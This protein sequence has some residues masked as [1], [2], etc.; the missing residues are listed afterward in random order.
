MQEN[1]DVNDSCTYRPFKSFDKK[2]LLLITKEIYSQNGF[3]NSEGE[4]GLH[5]A[6]SET[7]LCIYE[8]FLYN[9]NDNDCYKI[10]DI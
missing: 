6:S 8:A 10:I 7:M 2:Q 1:C 3:P 5:Y 4:E 9:V